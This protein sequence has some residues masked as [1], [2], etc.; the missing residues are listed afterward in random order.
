MARKRIL[1][2]SA[3][4]R[5]KSTCDEIKIMGGERKVAEVGCEMFRLIF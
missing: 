2:Q 5:E 1:R 4:R 3:G